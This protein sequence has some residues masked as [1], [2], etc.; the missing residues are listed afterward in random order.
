MGRILRDNPGAIEMNTL[1]IPTRSTR[2]IKGRQ[3]FLSSAYVA[4]VHPFG[5]VVQSH[6]TGT[7]KTLPASHAQYSE[8]AEAIEAALDN[9]EGNALCRALI[10]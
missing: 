8:Y 1:E 7:G 9:D 4:S 2:F 3:I 6:R 5:L 10:A